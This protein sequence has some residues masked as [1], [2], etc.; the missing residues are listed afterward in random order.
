MSP[1]IPL[2]RLQAGILTLGVFAGAFL[3]TSQAATYYV[4]TNGDDSRSAAQAQSISTPWRT[5]QKAAS[6]MVAGD[7]CQIRAGTY[8]EEVRPA[9]SGTSTSARITFQNYNGESVTV[10]GLDLVASGGATPPTVLLETESMTISASSGDTAFNFAD[11]ALSNGNGSSYDANAVGDYVTYSGSVGTAGT[12][13]VRVGVRR[14]NSR[15]IFQLQ[16]NGVNQGAAY[17]G[18]DANLQNVEVNLGNVAISTAG[19]QQFR[20]NITG[21]NAASTGYRV[22]L[23]YIK[24]VPTG[25]SSAW[26]VHSGSIYR[27]SIA[28]AVSDVFVDGVIQGRARFP[29]TGSDLLNQTWNTMKSGTGFTNGSV[30]CTVVDTTITQGSGTWNGATIWFQGPDRWF[31]RTGTVTSQ[32][33]TSLAV[34]VA[35]HQT[36]NLHMPAVGCVYFLTNSLAAL[37][38]AGEWHYDATAGQLYLWAPGSADPATKSV[39]V[40]TRRYAFNL[41][42][43]SYIRVAGI[44]VLA[45]T[46]TLENS[47]G[48]LVENCDFKYINS[49]FTQADPLEREPYS[50]PTKWDSTYNNVGLYL[51][52]SNN[53]IR[54]NLVRYSWGDGIN[55]RGS[56]NLVEQNTIHDVNFHGSGCAAITPH[57]SSHTI[58]NNTIHRTGRDGIRHYTNNSQI[59]YND[60]Y[61]IG[62]ICRDL[63]GTYANEPGY[64]FNA[65]TIIAYNWISNV[66]NQNQ[67]N[68]V[69]TGNIGVGIYIDNNTSGLTVHHNAIDNCTDSG[70][71][72]NWA[73]S[74]NLICNNT[75]Y[76]TTNAMQAW[77]NGYTQSGNVTRNNL[78]TTANWIGNTQSNNLVTSSPGFVNAGAGDFRLTAGSPAVNYGT[79]ISGITDGYVGAAPDAG[80]YEYGGTDWVAGA[81]ATPPGPTTVL[82]ET[83]SLTIAASS[84]DPA[85]NFNDAALSNG[86]GSTYDA[87]A[88]GDYVTYSGNVPTAG[89]YTVY[90]RVRK[91]DSRGIFQLQIDGTN[92]G[93]AYDGYSATLDH[94]EVNLGAKTLTA[95]S[96][97]FRFNVTGKNATSTGYRVVL[98]YIK[99]VP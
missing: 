4:A 37:D 65:G 3:T 1:R 70:I 20:F 86:A 26:T 55:V 13:N 90:V 38:S 22:V 68:P 12:Y 28:A 15:G 48:C 98:D 67:G 17:D 54:N 2:I 96:H 43:R 50:F 39:E 27:T 85:S 53:T 40:K 73:A 93:T 46:A 94:Q 52:G 30:N 29:N 74:N 9:N 32:S 35:N 69:A 45:A 51:S 78:S 11:A 64:N 83:E 75:L 31:S 88:S 34:T 57:G 76:N 97:Q 72:L 61:N 63:G 16:I 92:Q 87:N 18:Y 60:I 56:G 23:D 81:G 33:G 21:K 84:G 36:Y 91:W 80:A 25:S 41:N 49:F 66:G 24:L 89:T 71:R 59:I 19:T 8:R 82:L 42:D 95:G 62:L 47:V 14:W 77:L 58:R 5:I 99:L 6:A 44:N 79:P 7:A 10:T